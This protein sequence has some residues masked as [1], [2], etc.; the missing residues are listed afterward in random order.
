MLAQIFV[1]KIYNLNVGEK[2]PY[3]LASTNYGRVNMAL[4]IIV[5]IKLSSL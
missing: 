3:L 4:N 2:L 1:M 5:L